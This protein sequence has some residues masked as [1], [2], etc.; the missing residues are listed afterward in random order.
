MDLFGWLREITVG[1]HPWNTFTDED[2]KTWN[3][4]MI[5][6]YISMHEKYIEMA[7][8]LQKYNQQL[9]DEQMY[10]IYKS[11]IPKDNVW[12]KFI[13][14]SKNKYDKVELQYLTQH[15]QC[16]EREVKDYIELLPKEQINTILGNYRIETGKTKIKKAKKK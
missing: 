16:S 9:S 14:G 3:G 8:Y 15:F 5:H 2:K 12:L 11:I 10:N 1:K 7:N 13:K 4:Y 6:K